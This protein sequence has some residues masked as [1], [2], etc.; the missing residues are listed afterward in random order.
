MAEYT[1]L[2]TLR[3]GD[4][5]FVATYGGTPQRAKV[6][7]IGKLHIRVHGR[8]TTFRKRSGEASG[9]WPFGRPRLAP[10]TDSR[11]A[12]SEEVGKLTDLLHRLTRLDTANM[13]IEEVRCFRNGLLRLVKAS[14]KEKYDG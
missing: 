6:K 14:T 2:E 1:W 8:A 11:L 4:E 3:P 12:K 5:V 9:R 10:I 13:T 7:S